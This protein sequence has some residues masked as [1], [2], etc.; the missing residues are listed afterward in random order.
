MSA[1]R[2]WQATTERYRAGAKDLLFAAIPRSRTDLEYD[3]QPLVA[4][5]SYFCIRLV[6]MLLTRGRD[7]FNRWHPAVHGAVRLRSGNQ[8]A[9][10]FNR[11]AHAP[12]AAQAEG[13]PLNEMISQ[14]IPYNGGELE[15]AAALLALRGTRDLQLAVNLV[16]GFSSLVTS[17][18][19]RQ[20]VAITDHVA[21]G[22]EALIGEAHGEVQIA[23]HQFYV[24]QGEGGS[25]VL[26]PGYIAIVRAAAQTIRP[27]ELSVRADRLYLA[28][29]PFTGGDHMLLRVEG[30]AERDDW[31]LHAI[32]EPLEAAKAAIAHPGGDTRA[33]TM[34]NG[35]ILA[36]YDSPDL[37][38]ADRMRVITAIKVDFEQARRD[39]YLLSG[40]QGRV[41]LDAIVQTG[42]SRE[43]SI[44]GGKPAVED[45]LIEP[46]Q[47]NLALFEDRA[48]VADTR[49]LFAEPWQPGAAREEASRAETATSGLPDAGATAAP[50]A[51]SDTRPPPA[52]EP[53]TRTAYGL[54][55]C[56]D[57]VVMG[58][59]L[60]L[61]VGLSREQ[62][63]GVAGPPIE[64][65]DRAFQLVIQVV[66]PGFTPLA[67]ESLR[68]T[69]D[70]TAESPFPTCTIRLAADRGERAR[71]LCE[72]HASYTVEGQP[73]GF[74]VR[75]VTVLR[76]LGVAPLESP[77]VATGVNFPVPTAQH[78][79][80]L[81]VIIRLK[82]G[83][84]STLL[85]TFESRY[86]LPIPAVADETDIGASPQDFALRMMNQ[87]NQKQAAP[88]E[89][90]KGYG[91]EIS[92]LLPA[93]FWS[94]LGQVQK[95]A[96]CPSLLILSEDPFIPWELAL[97]EKPFDEHAAPFLGAQ[98]VVGRWIQPMKNQNR[99][100]VPP[101]DQV[102]VRA[103]AVVSGV[104]ETAA[105]L[106]EAEAE[107]TEILADIGRDLGDRA[108][109]VA[110]KQG[111][112]LKCLDG[113]P[114]ADL[115]HVSLHGS[116][117]TSGI[118][119]GLLL[120]DGN[121]LYPNQ[122]RGTRL[123]QRHPF[124]FLNACQVGQGS[125]LL[126]H[127]AGMAAA[128]LF[129]G[130]SAVI[131]PLW[132]IDDKVA[133]EI[134]TTFYKETLRGATAVPAAEVLR[135]ERAKF[136]SQGQSAT[137][138]AYQFFGHPEM[139]LTLTPSNPASPALPANP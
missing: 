32:V 30:R 85:W 58:A 28:G 69:L 33:T 102:E 39:R 128:F 133:H 113:E 6:G 81:T 91:D 14:L 24:P 127:Y 87:V 25:D 117:D 76:D 8:P 52:A 13:A 21:G 137:F 111:E 10:Y 131:A 138:V 46:R 45:L 50:A 139:T 51:A 35:A 92:Q 126:G 27:E 49:Q 103:A 15:V 5:Q 12:E 90:L 19:G 60:A 110:A 100:T 7:W 43:E 97:L 63:A 89:L 38:E 118:E 16:A 106:V 95:L 55:D 130:A 3:D 86:P 123:G 99:P 1:S 107:A 18:I 29:K 108:Q 112:I 41:D 96:P 9:R 116:F 136:L 2:L 22:I 98:A 75:Y 101:P 79:A 119:D 47:P 4:G 17:P 48:D 56:P 61:V 73:L 135:R 67:G 109:S 62:A 70:V 82:P 42:I 23:F 134:A 105:Q 59:T 40:G 77:Q 84:C 54:L 20:A 34:L 44:L 93:S 122:V 125:L 124:V 37:A 26:R 115:L 121:Y 94:L 74:A 129:A 114:T 71:A 53:P 36:V 120:V 57:T 88:F 132:S 83:L 78:A 80:D 11:L 66:A 31:R 64:V 68:Q 65:P 72:I 104:Y